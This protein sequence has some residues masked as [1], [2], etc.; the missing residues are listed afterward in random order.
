MNQTPKIEDEQRK[1]ID[2][3]IYDEEECYI[4]QR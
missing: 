3:M 4:S 1:D 2:E